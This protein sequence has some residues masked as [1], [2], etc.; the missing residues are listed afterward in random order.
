[1]AE[2]AQAEALCRSKRCNELK[3]A[4]EQ[5]ASERGRLPQ[6]ASIGRRLSSQTGIARSGIVVWAPA[7]WPEELAINSADA[8][9]T[10][11]PL[12]S[13]ECN[14]VGF[15]DGELHGYADSYPGLLLA[16]LRPPAEIF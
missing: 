12:R 7:Q 6:I 4:F 5:Q 11:H 10:E 14:I 1:M 13:I 15:R 16:I 2:A 9:H 8:K 3:L